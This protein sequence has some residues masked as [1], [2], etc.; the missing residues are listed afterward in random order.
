MT[1][2]T[3]SY[4]SRLLKKKDSTCDNCHVKKE[5]TDIEFADPESEYVLCVECHD[6]IQAE[7]DRKNEAFWKEME[8]GRK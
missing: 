3:T 8:A 7:N 2:Y 4:L 6:S 5:E 1:R